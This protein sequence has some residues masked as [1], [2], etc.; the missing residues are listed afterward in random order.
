MIFIN[1]KDTNLFILSVFQAKKEFALCEF[2]LNTIYYNA[3]LQFVLSFKH[4]SRS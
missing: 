2:F 3:K 1:F 4:A